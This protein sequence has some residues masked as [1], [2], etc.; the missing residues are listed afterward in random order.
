MNLFGSYRALRDN[1]I[2][3]IIAAIEVYNKPKMPYRSEC[4]VILLVNAWELILKAVLSKN[5]QRIF[6]PKKRGEKY[7]S[8]DI[9]DAI[10]AAARYFPSSIPN[11]PVVENIN[12]LIHYRNNAVHFYN[13]KDFDLLIYGLSQ[14]SIINFRD[15]VISIFNKDIADEINISLLPISFG[16]PPD[17]IEFI[18]SS[19]QNRSKS[20]SEYVKM[21][22]ETAKAL[23][24]GA[25]DTARFLTVYRI[26]LQST[27]KIKSADITA[28]IGSGDSS[29]GIILNR[30]VD[31]NESHPLRQKDVTAKIGE[32]LKGIKF[33][34]YVF[35]AI[36]WAEGIKENERFHWRD[37]YTKNSRYSNDIIGWLNGLSK[38]QI[39]DYVLRY[40]SR[41]KS[42]T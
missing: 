38:K 15:L 12:S 3:A 28:G 25:I 14:T 30:K 1:A 17:P 11:R 29:G 26:S 37:K 4:F 8:L 36:V 31:P 21:I 41:K 24:D 2:A 23:E 5:K 6:H 10:S 39:E 16:P 40:K 33:T 42:K 27:K 19:P 13:E 20:V 35:E 18:K 22:S 7:R 34:S 32:N 9:S